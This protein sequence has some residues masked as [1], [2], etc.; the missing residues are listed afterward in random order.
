MNCDK[1]TILTD[2]FYNKIIKALNF[3]IIYIFLN[4]KIEIYS[5][6]SLKCK[7]NYLQFK[8]LKNSQ[9]VLSKST[10]FYN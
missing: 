7:L 10:F 3:D 5:C 9:K 6:F 2:L 4:I 1:I 8:F